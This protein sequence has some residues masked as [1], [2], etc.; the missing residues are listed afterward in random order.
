[1]TSAVSIVTAATYAALA[2]A[3]TIA[4]A[5]LDPLLLTG[6]LIVGPAWAIA[7]TTQITRRDPLA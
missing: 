4:R 2:I 1:V 6:G 7:V 3:T 5:V